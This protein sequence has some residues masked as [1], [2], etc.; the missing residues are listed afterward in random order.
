[1]LNLI[2][3]LRIFRELTPVADHMSESM[4]HILLQN[5]VLAVWMRYDKYR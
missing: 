2:D 1:M 4:Q 5:A 3:K